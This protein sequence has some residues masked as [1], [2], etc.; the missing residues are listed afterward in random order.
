MR[1]QRNNQNPDSLNVLFILLWMLDLTNECLFKSVTRKRAEIKSMK[2]EVMQSDR[3]FM[4][5]KTI[6]NAILKK[7][8][9]IDATEI[10][11]A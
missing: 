7:S 3:F 2:T 5:H 1:G 11:S 10:V 4:L 8:H 9:K 6:V